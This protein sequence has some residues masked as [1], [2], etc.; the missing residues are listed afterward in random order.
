MKIVC[1]LRVRRTQ[2]NIRL[3]ILLIYGSV[4]ANRNG[5]PSKIRED[6][7]VPRVD[8]HSRAVYTFAGVVIA[9]LRAWPVLDDHIW[10][11]EPISGILVRRYTRSAHTEKKGMDPRRPPLYY[12][13]DDIIATTSSVAS[14]LLIIFSSF[15]VLV[16]SRLRPS[17]LLEVAWNPR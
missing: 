17:R 15:H 8:L 2:P 16:G 9:S 7:G 1:S 10:C 4:H 11:A 5:F 13:A 6:V 14:E 3:C 12:Y